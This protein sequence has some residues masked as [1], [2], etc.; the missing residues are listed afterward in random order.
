[1]ESK[2]IV[3]SDLH[4]DKVGNSLVL[5]VKEKLHFEEAK[6]RCEISYDAHLVEFWNEEEWSEVR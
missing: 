2:H 6:V 1:M 5:H 3:I 4:L